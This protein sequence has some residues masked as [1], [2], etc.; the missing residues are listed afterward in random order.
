MLKYG[1]VNP[2]NVHG[3][4]RT[5]HKPPHFTP[6]QF[7]LRV[8]EKDISDWIWANLTGRF[9]YGDHVEVRD[10]GSRSMCKVVAFEIA[11]E[12]SYFGLFIDKINQP[13]D[14]W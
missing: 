14:F 10:T 9:Y 3:L 1:E 2:L 6:F 5:E 13:N 7:D 12:A 11:S 8:N 4:R